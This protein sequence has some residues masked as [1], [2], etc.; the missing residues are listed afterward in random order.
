MHDDL[1]QYLITHVGIVALFPGGIH[2]MSI[3]QDVKIWPAMSFQLISLNEFAEDMEAPNDAKIDVASYQ[4][5]M[6]GNQSAQIIT[7]ADAFRSIFRNFRGT[8]G[9]TV[10]QS[11]T[12]G[13]TTQLE[14]RQGDKVRRRVVSDFL[15]TFNV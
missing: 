11:V 13:N 12:P 3:P 6:T 15:I 2:H 9:A 14:E 5:A 7:V 4:F 1:Y 10:V 8:M